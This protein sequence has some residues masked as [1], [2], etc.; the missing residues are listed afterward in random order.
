MYCLL[1]KD[2]SSRARASPKMVTKRAANFRRG[3]IDMMGVFRG[4]MFEVIKRPAIILPQASRFRGLMTEGEF[5]LIGDRGLKRGWPITTKNTRR[6]L[7]TAVNEV[8]SK[9]RERAQALR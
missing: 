1:V 4:V 8:A 7:Y 5:S 2:A 3:G 9:V 6:R